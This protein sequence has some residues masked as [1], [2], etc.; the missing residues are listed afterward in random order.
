MFVCVCN[1]FAAATNLVNQ[2]FL[3]LVVFESMLFFFGF[4]SYTPLLFLRIFIGNGVPKRSL[5]K[6]HAVHQFSPQSSKS[7][8]RRVISCKLIQ[9]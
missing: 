7:Q 9:S 6:V 4:L 3:M 1:Y 8:F 5:A 2:V